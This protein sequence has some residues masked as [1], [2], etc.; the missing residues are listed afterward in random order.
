MKSVLHCCPWQPQDSRT[1]NVIVVFHVAV[2]EHSIVA[3]VE[4]VCVRSVKKKK[5]TISALFNL[6]CNFFAV[7]VNTRGHAFYIQLN[8]TFF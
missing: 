5:P 6:F 8:S 7:E 3:V 1:V 2:V 4:L